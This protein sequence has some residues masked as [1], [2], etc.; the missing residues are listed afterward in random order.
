MG[1]SIQGGRLSGSARILVPLSL[2]VSFLANDTEELL[3]MA[4]TTP[5]ALQRL[6]GWV[7]VPPAMRDVDQH[8][9]RLAVALMGAL[10]GAAVIDGIATAGRGRLYQDV[11]LA[12]GAHGFGHLAASALTRGYTSGVFTSPSVVLPQWWWAQRTLRRH[13]VPNTSHPVRAALVVGGWLLG[14]HA[15]AGHLTRT[16]RRS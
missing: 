15:I 13:Q 2:W 1:T 8:H 5:G 7:R 10:Y 9:V 3:T 14:A 12:F 16:E 11:Q 6:P 4:S